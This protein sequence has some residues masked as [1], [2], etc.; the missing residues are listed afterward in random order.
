MMG[1]KIRNEIIIK[2]LNHTNNDKK[3]FGDL[4]VEEG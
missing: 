1:I 2:I 4:Y 3:K